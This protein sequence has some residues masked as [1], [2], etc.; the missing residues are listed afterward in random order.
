MENEFDKKMRERLSEAFNPPADLWDKIEG[1]LDAFEN[2]IE[3][4]K[5]IEISP[6]WK[7]ATAA[8]VSGIAVA[9]GFMFVNNGDNQ[10]VLLGTKA[11]TPVIKHQE[12]QIG[13]DLVPS[14]QLVS[15]SEVKQSL[16]SEVRASRKAMKHVVTQSSVDEQLVATNDS[17]VR[18]E[19]VNSIPVF[20][21]KLNT[22]KTSLGMNDKIRVISGEPKR[23][24]VDAELNQKQILIQQRLRLI[25]E[26]HK[27]SKKYHDLNQ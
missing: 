19:E 5:S 26:S 2:P 9:F 12:I 4:K 10:D 6:I 1:K 15:V 25:N 22:Q 7:Y 18:T 20:S 8:V 17:E 24:E 13:E 21:L 11:I 23:V 27:V 14:V 16:P 3:S